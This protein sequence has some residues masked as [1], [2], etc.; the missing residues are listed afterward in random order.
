M[1]FGMLSR[2]DPRNHVLDGVRSPMRTGNFEGKGMPPT[3]STTFWRELCENAWTDRDAVWVMDSGGPKEARIRWGQDLHTKG[4]LLGERTFSGMPDDILQW[5]VQKWL[6]RSIY[7]LG[8]GRGCA[9]GSSWEGTLAQFGEYDWTYV[10]LR[11]RCGLMSNF[12][13]HL[14][15]RM[16]KNSHCVISF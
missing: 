8:C 2:V 11:R 15:L 14:L 5:A 13:D 16:Y 6:N 7:H 12:F 3:C 4:Q 10:R 1:P 9:E